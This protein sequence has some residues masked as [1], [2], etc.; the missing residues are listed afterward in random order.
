[1]VSLGCYLVGDSLSFVVEITRILW[2]S[3]ILLFVRHCLAF[4]RNLLLILLHLA[5][6][7]LLLINKR[8]FLD[9][10]VCSEWFYVLPVLLIGT[11]HGLVD[12]SVG[13]GLIN[14]SILLWSLSV[15]NLLV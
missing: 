4:T 10:C 15:T 12:E 6:L 9:I 8:L 11:G 3:L 5:V 13:D 2:I 14:R 1:M 7:T